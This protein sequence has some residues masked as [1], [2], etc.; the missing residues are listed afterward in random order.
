[1]NI[2]DNSLN[3]LLQNG[4]SASSTRQKTITNNI[5]NAGT[6]NYKAKKTLFTHELNRALEDQKLKAYRTDERHIPFQN[7]KVLDERARVVTRK[8]TVMN[9]NGNSVDLEIEMADLAK[10]QIYYNAL[11]DRMNGR[12]NSVLTVLGRG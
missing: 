12:F 8:E 9:N 1:M 2:I 10:N 6:P 3:R 7:E 11:I 5:A 4:L